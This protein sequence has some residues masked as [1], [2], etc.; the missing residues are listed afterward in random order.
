MTAEQYAKDYFANKV[1]PVVS[2][3]GSTINGY[4]AQTVNFK[5]PTGNPSGYHVFVV[6]KGKVAQFIYYTDDYTSTYKAIID[7]IKFN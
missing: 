7:S 6:N 5:S 1:S 2:S 3:T 4:S